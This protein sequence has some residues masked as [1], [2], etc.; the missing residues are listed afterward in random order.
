MDIKTL[1][2][3]RGD[4]AKLK[5][6]SAAVKAG[7]TFKDVDEE[8]GHILIGKG[9]AERVDAVKPKADKQAVLSQTAKAAPSA[10]K[11]VKPGEAK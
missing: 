4:A 7:V 3:F 5:A 6:D 2:G 1:W 10:N 11:Q 8:Y 9:L